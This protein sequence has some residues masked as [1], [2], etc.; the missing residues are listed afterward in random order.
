MNTPTPTTYPALTSY[1]VTYSNGTVCDINMAA[2]VTLDDARDHFV[3]NA[4]DLGNGETEVM[5][6]AVS[7]EAL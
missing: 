2:G 4:F 5:A 7:V 6:T 1:R 3:G